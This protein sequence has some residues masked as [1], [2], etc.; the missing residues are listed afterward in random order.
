MRAAPEGGGGGAPS[1]T[2]VRR[3]DI[4]RH[5]FRHWFVVDFLSSM[6]WD[7]ILA[8]CVPADGCSIVACYHCHRACSVG[9]SA[10]LG[11]IFKALRALRLLR[12]FKLLKLNVLFNRLEERFNVNHHLLRLVKVCPPRLVA[13]AGVSWW[14]GSRLAPPHCF[15]SCS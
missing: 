3:K 13:P 12:L 11:H 2:I 1:E 8:A 4:A 9:G 6:P 15:I 5:F 10:S 14:R 7:P